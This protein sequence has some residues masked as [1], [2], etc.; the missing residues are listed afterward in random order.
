MKKN[1]KHKI[2]QKELYLK[3]YIFVGDRKCGEGE[4]RTNVE[5]FSYYL[6]L[7]K[8]SIPSFPAAMH[9]EIP[10]MTMGKPKHK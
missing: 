3:K 1:Y 5:G 2:V 6:S 9:N 8:L 7:V 10:T 4:K